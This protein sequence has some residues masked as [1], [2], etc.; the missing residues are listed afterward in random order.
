MT[1][2]K[3]D[4]K[5]FIT[6]QEIDGF[7]LIKSPHSRELRTIAKDLLD[8]IIHVKKEYLIKLIIEHIGGKIQDAGMGEDL[9]ITIEYF[10]GVKAHLL[11]FYG[12]DEEEL[13]DDLP[14]E[15]G[16]EIYFSGN[17]VKMVS[18]EDLASLI[19][20]SKNYIKDLHTGTVHAKNGEKENHVSDLL[21]R[22]IKQRS[23][24][25]KLITPAEIPDMAN[26]CGSSFEIK[27]GQEWSLIKEY[28]PGISITLEYFDNTIDVHFGGNNIHKIDNYAK[29]QLAIFLINHCLRFIGLA[30]STCE[31]LPD[32]VYKTYSFLYLKSMDSRKR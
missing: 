8:F 32:I 16:I 19:D 15:A 9:T 18:S 31:K 17:N 12:E 20:L 7:S 23:E 13:D 27:N 30:K 1:Y 5:E 11:I 26:F 25:F 4:K 28:F 22:S 2:E 10:P 14:V 29:D 3:I 21:R 6:I 24:P